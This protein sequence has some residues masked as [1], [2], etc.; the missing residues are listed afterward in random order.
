MLVCHIAS[1]AG[2]GLGGRD[3]ERDLT[4]RQRRPCG[5]AIVVLLASRPHSTQLSDET[6]HVAVSDRGG[7]MASCRAGGA[8]GGGDVRATEAGG[9]Q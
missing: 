9:Q 4:R 5:A 2:I 8:C 7:V 1:P 3:W 6:A